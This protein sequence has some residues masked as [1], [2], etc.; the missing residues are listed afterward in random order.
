M[1]KLIIEQVEEVEYLTESDESGSKQ[2][3][4]HGIFMQS[5][6][7][8]KNGRVYPHE[9]LEKEASRYNNEKIKTRSSYGELSHPDKPI[10]D[11]D[12]VSHLITELY[13]DG[14]N[15][16]GKARLLDT[17][18]GLIIQNLLDGG[19]AVGVSTRGVG[20]LKP[21]NGAQLVQPDFKLICV[22]AVL[23]PSAPSAWVQGI[24]ENKEW[25]YE[26]GE[27][28]EREYEIAKTMLKEASTEELETIALKLFSNYFS[29]L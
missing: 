1:G 17:P 11:P 3:Y 26:N 23:D 25:I 22:D 7:K 21:G 5:E 10:I 12:R 15:F 8:N 16:I 19:G 20:S 28:S 14:T 4:I 13:P 24:M 2:R 27:W 29:K 9:L 18:K 6:V